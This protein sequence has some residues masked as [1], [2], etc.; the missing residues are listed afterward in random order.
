MK[1]TFKKVISTFL[2]LAIMITCLP[3]VTKNVE[4]TANG[5]QE[6]INQILSV[7]PSGSYFTVSGGPDY[8]ANHKVY[9]GITCSDCY[10]PNIPSRGGLPSGAQTGATAEGCASFA[11][12]AYYC[13]FGHNH[14]TQTTYVSYPSLGDIVHM[15]WSWGG[16]HWFIYLGEDS[17][18][19]Y[20]YD[21][22][23]DADITQMVLYNHK[24]SKSSVGSFSEIM[25]A[26]NYDEING[27]SSTEYSSI[28]PGTYF[29]INKYD[30]K[31]LHLAANQNYNTNNVLCWETAFASREEHMVISAAPDG[32]KIRPIDSTRLVQPYGDHVYEGANVNIYDDVNDSSQWWKFEK[33][34]GGYYIRNAQNTN[35]LLTNSYPNDCNAVIWSYG[36]GSD[37][38]WELVP[39]VAPG[40]P[41]I[42]GVKSSYNQSESVV[43]DWDNTSDTNCYNIALERKENGEY[44]GI[45]FKEN[46]SHNYNLN[47]VVDLQPGDYRVRLASVNTKLKADY[48]E[49]GYYL[50]T[51]GDYA[52]FTVKEKAAEAK[53]TIRIDNASAS[54]GQTLKVPVYIDNAKISSLT[55][56]VKYDPAVLEFV[57]ADENAFEAVDVNVNNIKN[58][59]IT[60]ACLNK[61]TEINGKIVVLSFK[62]LAKASC[63]TSVEIFNTEA[64]DSKDN[65]IGLS[66]STA[67]ISINTALLGDVNNDGKV[68]IIDARWLL[69]VSSG[70][71]TLN[72]AQKA[73][74]DVNGDK[75]VNI[76]DARWLL[77]VASGSR[78]L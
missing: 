30:G 48:N 42:K 4:A 15:N 5:V 60:L 26:T 3:I 22:N 33:T 63:K 68:N 1:R 76:I 24:I 45:Y 43:V 32:Y 19:Y 20:I 35:L 37:Q 70:S 69:Q 57:S 11:I 41:A 23:A 39:A 61:E 53:G 66:E 77:Q 6:K 58:G 8:N 25:H 56:S 12:Y 72:D 10:L 2:A 34:E 18:S 64:Y 65:P 59:T 38:I 49:N 31:A 44:K 13:I 52:N 51:I 50:S 75:K 14:G 28:T 73:V 29:I 47:S 54:L 71:R 74:S 62:T 27:S 9:N 7:Y 17:N 55:F 36:G 16:E 78:T 46:I 67:E 21:A 40:K